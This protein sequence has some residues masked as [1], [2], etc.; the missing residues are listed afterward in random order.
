MHVLDIS[1]GVVAPWGSL[2]TSLVA[3]QFLHDLSKHRIDL[4]GGVSVRLFRGLNFN[5]FAGAS[6]I[7]NQL[8][9]SGAGLTPE[10]RLQ[11]T[12]QFETDFLFFGTI[13]FSYRFGSSFANVVNTRLG[14]ASG[15]IF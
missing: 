4:T 8:Y 7:K 13:G 10:E 11:R 2:N 15:S 14:R 1:L 5:L 6:R 9:I 12:G 3:S